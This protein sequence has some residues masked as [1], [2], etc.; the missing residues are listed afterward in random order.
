MVSE[1]DHSNRGKEFAPNN[2]L[3]RKVN[4]VSHT[5]TKIPDQLTKWSILDWEI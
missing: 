1:N 3:Q 5:Q 2:K 4:I